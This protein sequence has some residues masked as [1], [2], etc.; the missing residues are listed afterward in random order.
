M[1]TTTTVLAGVLVFVASQFV[2]KLWIEPAIEFRRLLARLSNDIL[3]YQPTITNNRTD[4]DLAKSLK[5]H[6]ARLRSSVH[7]LP[8][9]GVARVLFALPTE[10]QILSACRELNGIAHNLNTQP[11]RNGA[12]EN[13]IAIKRVGEALGVRTAYSGT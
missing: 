7:V 2:L 1:D 3:F 12:E 5:E 9:Y 10:L 13:S 8:F 6:A 4:P 11:S